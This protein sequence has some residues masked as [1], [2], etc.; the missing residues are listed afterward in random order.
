MVVDG[1]DGAGVGG[2]LEERLPNRPAKGLDKRDPEFDTAVSEFGLLADR[3]ALDGRGGKAGGRGGR[4]SEE[5]Y[6]GKENDGYDAP[7]D[8]KGS[9]GSVASATDVANKFWNTLDEGA[10][11]DRIVSVSL[12]VLSHNNTSKSIDTNS[13]RVPLKPESVIIWPDFL[14]TPSQRTTWSFTRSRV[15]VELE[16][17]GSRGKSKVAFPDVNNDH[18]SVHSM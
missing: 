4:G 10:N 15:T 5:V 2:V 7:K 6:D 8:I 14:D 18:I 16:G 9:G 13:F 3:A 12:R 11:E 17:S 1:V